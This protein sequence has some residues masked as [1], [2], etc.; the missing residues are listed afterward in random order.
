MQLQFT[1][2]R[3]SLT[4]DTLHKESESGISRRRAPLIRF[5]V[6]L[7]IEIRGIGT[8]YATTNNIAV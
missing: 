1:E 2:G 4:V 8:G 7:T 6:D 5:V 3:K